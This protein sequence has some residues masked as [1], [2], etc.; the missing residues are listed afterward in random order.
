MVQ[1]LARRKIH[2]RALQN[3]KGEDRDPRHK[4]GLLSFGHAVYFGLGGYAAIH[5]MRA[6]NHGWPIPIPLVPLAGAAAGL[7]FGIVFGSVSTRRS[8]TI[9]ALISLGVGELVIP[10]DGQAALPPKRAQILQLRE[11]K[12]PAPSAKAV[13][14]DERGQEVS[15]ARIATGE[16]PRA[17]RR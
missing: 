4:R 10:M 6:I 1:H 12:T 9:F 17:I 14:D 16:T 15:T 8:G 2:R 7:L 11:T 13:A 3:R 5:L